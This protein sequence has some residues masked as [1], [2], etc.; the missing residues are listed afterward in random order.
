MALYRPDKSLS[1]SQAR[2]Y[3]CSLIKEVGEEHKIVEVDSA[4][5]YCDFDRS[6]TLIAT[7]E[8]VRLIRK[9]N[10]LCPGDI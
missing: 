3:F 6:V 10:N 4:F 1:I 2:K 7:S 8:Y 9:L 5:L